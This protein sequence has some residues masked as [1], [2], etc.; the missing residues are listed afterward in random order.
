MAKLVRVVD[1]N[2]IFHA[3]TGWKPAIDWFQQ[4]QEGNA[5]TDVIALELLRGTNNLQK[6]RR[7][8]AFINSVTVLR[9]HGAHVAAARN[10]YRNWDRK[11]AKNTPAIPDMMIAQVAISASL[12]VFTLN[13]KDFESVPGLPGLVKP[14]DG[15][16]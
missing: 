2:I 8:E 11:K 16:T 1:S 14:F 7:T 6:R 13:I 5:I 15:P 10:C 9:T 4:N 3:F 12:P